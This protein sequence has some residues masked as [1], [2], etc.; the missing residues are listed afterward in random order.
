MTNE[1]FDEMID[2]QLDNYDLTDKPIKKRLSS[3]SSSSSS[4]CR[5]SC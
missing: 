1:Q 2:K 4:D 3:F 5:C